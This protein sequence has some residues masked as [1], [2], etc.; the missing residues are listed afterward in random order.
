MPATGE[1]TQ[2]RIARP[3]PRLGYLSLLS[4]PYDFANDDYEGAAS[5][6][7][8]ITA[9]R[10]PG[11]GQDESVIEVQRV[12]AGLA[13]A[14]AATH[15]TT[16]HP[17]K[18]RTLFSLVNHFLE[19]TAIQLFQY[20]GSIEGLDAPE[21][22][23]VLSN[24]VPEIDR[25]HRKV[26]LNGVLHEIRDVDI[27]K[28]DEIIENGRS[29]ITLFIPRDSFVSYFSNALAGPS[30]KHPAHEQDRIP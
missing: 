22:V 1:G 11:D 15:G 9:H 4:L 14:L 29:T 28:I 3:S 17:L 5:T 19:D 6:L 27:A 18:N 30:L 25:I 12:A 16:E 10:C 23:S 7:D 24:D 8:E 20:F 21:L 13:V 2:T 26:I